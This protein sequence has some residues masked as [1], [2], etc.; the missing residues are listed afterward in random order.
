MLSW[1]YGH[2]R[3]IGIS[4]LRF[5]N[6]GIRYD[7]DTPLTE[8]GSPPKVVGFNP[9]AINPVCQC[10]GTIT[11]PTLS[12]RDYNTSLPCQDCLNRK[13]AT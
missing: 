12:N 8:L 10:P 4:G 5:L 11:F 13:A 7:V 2:F 3:T 1:Y 6:L 9:G